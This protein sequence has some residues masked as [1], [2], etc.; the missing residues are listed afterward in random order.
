MG[1]AL[2]FRV[3]FVPISLAIDFVLSVSDSVAFGLYAPGGRFRAVTAHGASAC[4][5]IGSSWAGRFKGALDADGM[6]E[7]MIQRVLE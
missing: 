6:T 3:H 7:R 2:P 1:S 4:R 5:T